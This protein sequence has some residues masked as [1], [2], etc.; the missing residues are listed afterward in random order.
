MLFF[1]LRLILCQ[2][3]GA[4]S[5]LLLLKIST[6]LVAILLTVSIAAKALGSLQPPNPALRGFTEGCEDKP[7]PCWYG[8]VPGVT[9]RSEVVTKLSEAKTNYIRVKDSPRDDYYAGSPLCNFQVNYPSDNTVISSI[10]FYGC[11]DVRLGD[12]INII[13]R[14][15][16][17]FPGELK[18]IIYFAPTLEV[19]VDTIS[20]FNN[21]N[22]M[23]L[24][25][26]SETFGQLTI[27][28]TGFMF[29]NRYCQRQF[30]LHGLGQC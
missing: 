17:I 4:I 1:V 25:S 26:E 9:S 23:I 20:L 5:I 30:K 19:D 13:G 6:Y 8:I 11:F 2:Q 24:W 27:Q 22:M 15:I 28:W 16:S 21:V 7:Q 3:L 12:I 14:P 29:Q 18:Q 10:G